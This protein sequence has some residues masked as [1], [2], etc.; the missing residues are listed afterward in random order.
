[1]FQKYI[2]IGNRKQKAPE[3]TVL[4]KTSK[5]AKATAKQK[6]DKKKKLKLTTKHVN[7][8]QTKRQ[9]P[10]IAILQRVRKT[11]KKSK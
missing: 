7:C 8:L 10:K 2:P 3:T 9:K 6:M 4:S 5:V 1:M 11:E